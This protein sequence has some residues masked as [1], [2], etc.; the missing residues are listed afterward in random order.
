MRSQRGDVEGLVALLTADATWSMPP[1]PTWYSGDALTAFLAG[2]AMA[3]RWRH[4]PTRA[5][6]HLAVGCYAWDPTHGAFVASG[7][8]TSSPFGAS[9]IAAVDGF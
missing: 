2:H 6:G 9:G 1:I 4:V 3:V 7:R 5:S 8:S